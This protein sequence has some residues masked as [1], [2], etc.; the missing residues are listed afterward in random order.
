MDVITLGMYSSP[1]MVFS[2]IVPLRAKRASQ[3]VRI[4][5]AMK[6]GEERGIEEG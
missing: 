5:G 6:A 1:S 4:E 2:L 3:E